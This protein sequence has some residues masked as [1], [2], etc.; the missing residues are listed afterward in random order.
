MKSY[1]AR[2]T[3]GEEMSRV[4]DTIKWGL[5]PQSFWERD[6][7]QVCSLLSK[8]LLFMTKWSI[9]PTLIITQKKFDTLFPSSAFWKHECKNHTLFETK[10]A[11]SIPYFWPEHTFIAHK[12]DYPK[13]GRRGAGESLSVPRYDQQVR[14]STW[15]LLITRSLQTPFFS[16]NS[17]QPR[18]WFY[19]D[20][21]DVIIED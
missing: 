10:I 7:H 1:S 11:R 2:V 6:S 16:D 8:T 18:E 14:Y 4:P 9:F 15:V 3:L 21:L 20:L 5:I 19:F 13:Y 17:L 12:R